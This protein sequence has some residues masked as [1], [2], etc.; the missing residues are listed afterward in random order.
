MKIVNGLTLLL[1]D[2]DGTTSSSSSLGVLT[3]NTETPVMTETTVGSDLLE[4]FQILTQFA[5][6]AVCQNLRVL[7]VYNISLSIQEP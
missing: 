1:A 3:S 4:T 6:H 5:F 2:T 7:A